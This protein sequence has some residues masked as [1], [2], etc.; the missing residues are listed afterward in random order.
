MTRSIIRLA[1]LAVIAFGLS[2]APCFAQASGTVQVKFVKASLVVGGGGGLGVLS[3][4]GKSYK[5]VISGLSLGVAAGASVSRL[6]GQV[7]GLREIGDFAGTY[8]AVGGGGALVGGVGGVML[9]NE[10]GVVL[11]LQ[12][13]KAGLEFAANLSKIDISLR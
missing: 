13:P 4:R 9:R 7:S 5:F 1:V 6:R 8:A 2:A 12:G 10:K 3:Y 11:T